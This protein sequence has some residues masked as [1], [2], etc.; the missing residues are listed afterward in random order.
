M[1]KEKKKTSDIVWQ[2]ADDVAEVKVQTN[3]IGDVH[4]NIWPNAPPIAHKLTHAS[5]INWTKTEAPPLIAI[6]ATS[7]ISLQLTNWTL[8]RLTDNNS[9]RIMQFGNWPLRSSEMIAFFV[10]LNSYGFLSLEPNLQVWSVS[11][12]CSAGQDSYRELSNWITF[13]ENRS[14]LYFTF[15]SQSLATDNMYF[16]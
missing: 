12:G 5:S 1:K 11:G 4:E 10:F 9:F 8:G 2:D 13:F 6:T 15:Y 14:T 7:S 16:I 3:D